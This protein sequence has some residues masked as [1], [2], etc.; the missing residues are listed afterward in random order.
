MTKYRFESGHHPSR[1]PQ[2]EPGDFSKANAGNIAN[3]EYYA[4]AAKLWT[5][6][7]A[8]AT[9]LK[10]WIRAEEAGEISEVMEELHAKLVKYYTR[11]EIPE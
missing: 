6:E 4:E 2:F 7:H 10:N 5:E 3:A 11:W 1:P 8:E 9:E